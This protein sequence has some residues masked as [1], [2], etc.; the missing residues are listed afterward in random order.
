MTKEMKALLMQSY[1]GKDVIKYIEELEKEYDS[2]GDDLESCLNA[3]KKHKEKCKQLEKALD[4]ACKELEDFEWNYCLFDHE[5]A[6][7]KLCHTGKMN[8]DKE[9]WKAWCLDENC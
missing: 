7:S 6:E 1:K 9:E 3:R 8:Y 5:Y 2:L 4:K